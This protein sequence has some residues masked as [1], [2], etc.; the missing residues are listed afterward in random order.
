MNCVLFARM[1]QVFNLTR[2]HYSRMCDACTVPY[3][4]GLPDRGPPPGQGPPLDR[5]APLWTE[6]TPL[7]GIFLN[8]GKWEACTGMKLERLTT[9]FIIANFPVQFYSASG[10]LV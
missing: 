1:D 3:G 2:M 9:V 8:P 5:D 7:E 4:G 10:R 6:K